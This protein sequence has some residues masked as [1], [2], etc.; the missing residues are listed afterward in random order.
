[1]WLFPYFR[2][3]WA[4]AKLTARV[5][6][7]SKPSHNIV[8]EGVL[9]TYC[10]VVNHILQTYAR[11][12]ITERRTARFIALWN[13]RPCAQYTLLMSFRLRN[14][15]AYIFMAGIGLKELFFKRLMQSIS[16]SMRSFC[17]NQ[18]TTAVQKL[19]CHTK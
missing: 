16:Y 17:S 18:R 15:V 4:P 12:D 9:R 6:L 10:Q 2:R 1:M 14:L 13:H 8:K 7:K 3:K 5:S 11:H 19:A